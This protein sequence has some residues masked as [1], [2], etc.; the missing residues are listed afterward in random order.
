MLASGAALHTSVA[1]QSLSAADSASLARAAAATVV[2]EILSETRGM[3]VEL[4]APVSRFDSLVAREIV[5]S[6]RLARPVASAQ[7]LEVATRGMHMVADN[8]AVMIEVTRCEG[9][10]GRRSCWSSLEMYQYARDGGRWKPVDPGGV[11]RP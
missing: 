10:G 8:P 5:A 7:P 2:S 11:T 1:A 3:P 9:S 6:G 4:T